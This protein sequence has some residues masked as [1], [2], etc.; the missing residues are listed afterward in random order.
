MLGLTLFEVL[1]PITVGDPSFRV[2]QAAIWHTRGMRSKH[3]RHGLTSGSESALDDLVVKHGT[4]GF[5]LE[6]L[7]DEMLDAS[8]AIAI[9]RSDTFAVEFVNQSRSGRTT[10]LQDEYWDC[11][12]L[13][14]SG[15]SCQLRS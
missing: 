10:L 11:V 9:L 15:C 7:V 13:K 14:F 8:V 3:L 5:A 6:F 1:V 4:M 12:G 2:I